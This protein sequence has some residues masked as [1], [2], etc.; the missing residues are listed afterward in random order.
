MMLHP[1]IAMG[2]FLSL[3]LP[4]LVSTET[5]SMVGTPGLPGIPGFPGRNG[6]DG[7][8][9]EKGEAG[10]AGGLAQSPVKGYQGDTGAPGATGK[11]GKGGERGPSGPLGP[12][13]DV[14]PPGGG[15]DRSAFS[16]TRGTI[17]APEK[18]KVVKFKS[19]ITNIHND[20]DTETGH[21]RCRV[22]GTYYFVYHASS[23]DRLCL[24][25][26][27]D[28]TT[29]AA[30]CELSSNG[31]RQVSSGGLAMHLV[32][33]QEVWLQTNDNNGMTGKIEGTSIFSGFLLHA[34]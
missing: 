23:E 28:D 31:V 24:Q 2:A 13:G 7:E 15:S 29:M 8:Q 16:V 26:K 34:H 4:V 27:V 10:V 17:S 19:V 3:I 1:Y 14:G 22:P 12:P 20:Y 25:L 32:K 9:G 30:F 6:R 5:C 18:F 11:R 21:F 33:D